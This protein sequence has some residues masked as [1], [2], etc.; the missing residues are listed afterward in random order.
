MYY[1]L[2]LNFR[3]YWQLSSKLMGQLL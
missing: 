3:Q 2:R 1:L